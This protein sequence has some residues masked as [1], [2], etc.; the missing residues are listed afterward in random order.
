[1]T[2]IA[3]A[4]VAGLVIGVAVGIVFA[5]LSCAARKDKQKDNN[6]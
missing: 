1:M 2:V 6:E 3:F 4:F 5:G